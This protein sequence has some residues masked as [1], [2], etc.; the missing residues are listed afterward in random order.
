MNTL[1]IE[2]LVFLYN[3]NQEEVVSKEISHIE[4]RFIG[5]DVL[6]VMET[7]DEEQ[8]LCDSNH[9]Q[10]CPDEDKDFDAAYDFLLKGCIE[11]VIIKTIL[12]F[13]NNYKLFRMLN[14]CVP[15]LFNC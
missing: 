3:N 2:D 10:D 8:Q 1:N 13:K 11:E 6:E 9:L 12:K 7:D 4:D 15:Y 5:D 14:N